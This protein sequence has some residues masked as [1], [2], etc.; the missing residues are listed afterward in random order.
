M[1]DILFEAEI[2][3]PTI[4][5]LVP[6]RLSLGGYNHPSAPG[7]YPPRL[8]LSEAF[9]RSLWREGPFTSAQM[10]WGAVR[11]LNLDGSLNW[12]L[13]H[14]CAVDGRPARLL[15]GDGVAAYGSFIPWAT[16]MMEQCFPAK[17]A[18]I[19]RWRDDLAAVIDKTLQSHQF[20]GTNTLP[21]G[22]EGTAD[23]LKDRWVPCGYGAARNVAPPVANTVKLVLRVADTA[24]TVSAVRDK[25]VP[26]PILTRVASLAAFMAATVPAGTA[27]WFAGSEGTFAR[28][29]SCSGQLTVDVTEGSSA[30]ERTA[31]QIFRRMLLR[32]GVADERIHAGDLAALDVAAPAEVEFWTGTEA[33]TGRTALDAVAGT[34]GADYWLDVAGLWR[35]RRLEAPAG[36]P[37]LTFRRFGLDQAAGAADVDIIDWEYLEDT[38]EARGV[39]PYQTSIAWGWNYTVQRDAD[40]G[41]DKTRSDDPVGGIARRSWLGV[42]AR[43]ASTPADAA[44]RITHPLSKPRT[45]EATRFV[46]EADAAAE[47]LRRQTLLGVTRRRL[48]LAVPWDQV[49]ERADLGQGG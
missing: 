28:V 42:A 15:V 36:P 30:A 24:C 27:L 12:L 20:A 37:V 4:S 2:W 48:R 3:D 18:V 19:F 45:F 25:G 16:G 5:G 32:L 11:A 40:L 6:L 8:D 41:G 31:A 35:I 34:A 7:Y 13:S 17:D 47:A 23:D 21:D 49:A 46:N 14:E 29:L 33:V 26:Y 38:G 39:P 44:I 43:T 1:Q 9:T 22:I 10:A